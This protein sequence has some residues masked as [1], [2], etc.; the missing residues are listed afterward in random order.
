MLGG[1]LAD[2]GHGS[3]VATFARTAASGG[4][5]DSVAT[6]LALQGAHSDAQKSGAVS[7]ITTG[8]FQSTADQLSFHGG[9][10]RACGKSGIGGGP[11]FGIG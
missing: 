11:V 5:L 2:T 10:S 4:N 7:S 1:D 8:G 3:A 6:N 9:Q